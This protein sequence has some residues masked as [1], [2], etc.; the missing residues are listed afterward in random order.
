MPDI[1]SFIVTDK[2]QQESVAKHKKKKGKDGASDSDEIVPT[3][4]GGSRSRPGR[5]INTCPTKKQ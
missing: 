3:K 2:N 1:D 5:V 4:G